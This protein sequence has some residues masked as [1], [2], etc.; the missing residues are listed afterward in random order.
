MSRL[1][2]IKAIDDTARTEAVDRHYDHENVHF[3]QKID[4]MKL[5][6]VFDAFSDYR[7]GFAELRKR[8]NGAAT[9]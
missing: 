3:L 5:E 4:M 9:D 7:N 2:C 8:T 6:E 1:K